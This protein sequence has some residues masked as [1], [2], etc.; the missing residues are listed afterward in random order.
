MGRAGGRVTMEVKRYNGIEADPEGVYVLYSDY[1]DL[2]AE[3]GRL[4]KAASELA[5]GHLQAQ[6]RAAVENTRLRN[7]LSEMRCAL[8]TAA[9]CLKGHREYE[10]AE[11]C[12]RAAL[13]AQPSPEKPAK[14]A[15]GAR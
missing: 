1:A 4:E 6:H 9:A 12:L 11:R 8:W 7:E 5:T 14:P 13:S 2:H 10:A 15:G 3:V